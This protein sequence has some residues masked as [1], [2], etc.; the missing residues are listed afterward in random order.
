[1]DKIGYENRNFEAIRPPLMSE[2]TPLKQRLK[3]IKV[4][5]NKRLMRSRTENTEKKRLKPL[6]WPLIGGVWRLSQIDA[7][8]RHECNLCI[9]VAHQ[10]TD[11]QQ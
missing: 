10:N 9:F 11:G 7:Q 3:F 4:A 1:M 2:T 6:F 8:V 5:D